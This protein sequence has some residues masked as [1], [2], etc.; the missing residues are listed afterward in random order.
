MAALHGAGAADG[1][2]VVNF[3]TTP[4]VIRELVLEFRKDRLLPAAGAAARP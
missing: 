2:H 1:F 4:E 3:G